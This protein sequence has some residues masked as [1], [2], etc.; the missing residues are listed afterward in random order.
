MKKILC[1]FLTVFCMFSTVT[2]YGCSKS[3]KEYE[4]DCVVNCAI[5]LKSMMKDPESFEIYGVCGYKNP[6]SEKGDG[7]GESVII[8][9]RATNSYGAYG[10]DV[11]YFYNGNYLG[12]RSDYSDGD[13]KDLSK[14]NQIIFLKIHMLYLQGDYNKTYTKEQVNKK[15]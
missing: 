13:Y 12:S 2:I 1:L 7:D 4:F 9:Y 8:P 5:K 14:T 11:A 6:L 3:P 10:T 15:I